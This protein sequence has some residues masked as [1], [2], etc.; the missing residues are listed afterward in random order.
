MYSAVT[1]CTPENSS[2]Q[3]FS[4]ITKCLPWS[5]RWITKSH[6][7]LQHLLVMICSLPWFAVSTVCDKPQGVG[8]LPG[9]W[10]DV[11]SRS[12]EKAVALISLHPGY[13]KW[14]PVWWQIQALRARMKCFSSLLL[15]GAWNLYTK[16]KIKNRRLL[17]QRVHCICLTFF[18]STSLNPV[19]IGQKCAFLVQI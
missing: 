14:C 11:Y 16:G 10:L 15:P 6:E 13:L 19:L 8:H 5:K 1:L 12:I 2:K 4:I 7:A 18:Q 17:K 3:K 9:A